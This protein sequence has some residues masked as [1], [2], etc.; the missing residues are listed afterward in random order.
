MNTYPS[1]LIG[2]KL[3]FLMNS[4]LI[5][6]SMMAAFVLDAMTVNSAFQSRS[7]TPT[8]IFQQDHARSHVASYVR[9]FFS[10]Q[11][12]QLLPVSAYSLDMSAFEHVWDLV[13]RCL[14]HDPDPTAS[15]DELWVRIQTIWIS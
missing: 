2:N 8:A 11:H 15:K 6:G 3:S 13:P 12:M 14:V 7:G 4:T 9:D 1:D 5:C 10:V